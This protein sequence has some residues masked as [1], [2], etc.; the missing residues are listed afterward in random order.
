MCSFNDLTISRKPANDFKR[1]RLIPSNIKT[2]LVIIDIQKRRT[3]TRPSNNGRM[4]GFDGI[5]FGDLSGDIE[6]NVP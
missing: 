1:V 3:D 6:S 5:R 2:E 4:C